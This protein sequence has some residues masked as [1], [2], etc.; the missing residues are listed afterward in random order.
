MRICIVSFCI[1]VMFFLNGCAAIAE[2]LDGP[3]VVVTQRQA[4]VKIQGGTF[5]TVEDYINLTKGI[6]VQE[7][8]N[9]MEGMYYLSPEVVDIDE[10]GIV[11]LKTAK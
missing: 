8:K 6:K 2:L 3:R 11:K 1:A 10:H 7:N 5:I 4:P 9:G